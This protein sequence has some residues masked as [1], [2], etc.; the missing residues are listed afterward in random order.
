M[1]TRKLELRDSTHGGYRFI[2]RN[3]TEEGFT[4]V[5]FDG[6]I[7]PREEDAAEIVKRWNAYPE[8]VVVLRFVVES[9]PIANAD[10]NTQAIART[11]L[12]TLNA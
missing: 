9:G 4:L 3:D 1:D 5:T 6:T 12:A 8:L 2:D 7:R 11:L 10:P